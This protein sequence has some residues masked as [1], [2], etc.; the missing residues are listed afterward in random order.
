MASDNKLIK[1]IQGQDWRIWLGTVITFLWLAGGIW[2]VVS[3]SMELPNQSFSPEAVGGF[4]EGAFAPLAFLWLVLGLFI[5]Q[6]ELANNTEALRLTSEQSVKQT[7]AIA[8][9][10]M[11]ARQESFFKIADNVKHQL[12]GISGMLFASGLGPIGSG[13]LSREQIDDHFT[14]A[15][16]G[17]N[18]VFARLFLSM[19]F[20]EEG[21][22]AELLYG[23]E[24]RD[25]HSRNYMRAFDR[26]CRLARN[27]DVDSIIE[28]SLM[29]SALG[30]LYQRMIEH[31]PAD[32][33]PV[34]Q[35]ES[36]AESKAEPAALN[37]QS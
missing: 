37:I 27:C 16:N 28:D 15:A 21:G 13:R 31:N 14:Q 3:V 1:F 17:D 36:A 8:A 6:R 20:L 5:Q 29:Q 7:Q 34:N 11:N 22:I 25:R 35:I 9:T 18:E 33:H 19:H 23:T 24:I 10:E 26:L 12:G 2:Y 32:Q 4:L 30:L